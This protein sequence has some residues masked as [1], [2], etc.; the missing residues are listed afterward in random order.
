MHLEEIIRKTNV[1]TLF[2]LPIFR[3]IAKDITYKYTRVDYRLTPLLYEHGLLKTYCYSYLSKDNNSL[4]LVFDKNEVSRKM[5]NTN[6]PGQTVNQVLLGSKFFKNLDI[7]DDFAIYNL[8]IPSEYMD[9]IQLIKLGKYSKLSKEYRDLLTVSGTV[10]RKHV[11]KSE[12]SH[13]IVKNN[14]AAK[15]VLKDP[16][17]KEDLELTLGCDPIPD[18]T[19][20]Y[21]KFSVVK[22]TLTPLVLNDLLTNQM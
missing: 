7:V 5:T 16:S 14:I 9:D 11:L 17:I 19:E 18:E 12:L 15:V 13:T 10:L 22:E 20:L 4:F 1:S 3:E 2:I 21:T 6:R 8:D